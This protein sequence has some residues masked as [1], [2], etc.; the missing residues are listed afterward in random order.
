MYR[1]GQE[2][3]EAVARVIKSRDLFRVNESNREVDN[4]EKE[5]AEK[6]GTKYA[7]CLSGGTAALISSLVGLGIGPGDE[8]IIPGYTFMATAIAVLAVGAIPVITD[9]DDSLTIDP[10]DIERKISGYTKAIIPVHMVGFPCN[11]EKIMEIA[12]KH[13]L[14]VVEDACQA[15]GGSYKGKRLGTWGDVGAFSFNHFKILTAGEGGAIV[16]NDS[17]VYERALIYH[18]GGAAFR[19]FAKELSVD[20]FIGSQY[21]ASEITGAIMRVQLKRLDEILADLRKIKKQFIDELSGV[22]NITFTRSNDPDGDCGTTLGLSFPDEEKARKF[23][24]S[25]GV[26]GWLPIDSGKHVYTNWDPILNKRGAH[27]PALNP[28]LLP[29]N[30][31]LNMN[32]TKTM[33]QKTLDILSK[34]VYISLET[35]WSE[36][37]IYKKIEY[38]RKAALN[39]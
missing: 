5:L 28:Y 38:C 29:Q 13:K 30:K 7:L 16:T 9:I 35:D 19:P 12:K 36:D 10:E 1:I 17:L 21:R 25:E 24:Q 18:D 39:L 34:N 23:A 26:D 4:F 2:E 11:M 31:N 3:I 32:Y 37:K 20:V 27:H 22:S 14:K 6:I 15:D 8:V 33:C